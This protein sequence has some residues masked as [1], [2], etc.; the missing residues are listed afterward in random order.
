MCTVSALKKPKQLHEDQE[1]HL[2]KTIIEMFSL[3]LSLTK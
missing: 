1:L 3:E 2:N